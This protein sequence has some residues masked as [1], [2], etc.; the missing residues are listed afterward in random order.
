MYDEV[1]ENTK[2]LCEYLT[3]LYGKDIGEGLLKK[4]KDNLFGFHGLAW[5]VA[6]RSIE[7]FCLYFLQD[8][9]IPKPNNAARKLAPVHY[10]MWHE[11][12]KMLVHDEFDKIVMAEPRGT[13]KTTTLDFGVTVWAHCYKVSYYTIVM[14]K[15]EGDAA[16]FIINV[17]RAFEDNLY[18]R[19]AFGI[20]LDPKK[21]IVNREILELTNGT[22][23]QALSSTSS[24]RGKKY[25]D[26]RPSLII[27]DDA[28]SKAD[29]ITAEARDKKYN[30]WTQ[31]AEYA[32][33]KAVY[34][35]GKKI[36]MA[37]KFIVLGT[38][39]HSS[40]L[41]SRLLKSNKYRHILRRAVDFDVD[42]YFN[43]EI[44]DG[45]LAKA[46]A[47]WN[48]FRKIYG[49][50]RLPG[51]KACAEEFYSMHEDD[52]KFNT[53]WPDKFDCL[54]LATDYYNDPIAFKQEMQN[55][56]SK[57]GIRWFK[58][59]Q[60]QNPEEINSHN[61]IKTMLCIDPAN[62]LDRKADFTA[63][64]VG[65]VADTGFR[66]IRKGIIE[67]LPFD[68]YCMAV[69]R[70]L[71]EYPDITHIDIE[72]NTYQG[73][74]VIKIKEL[75]AKT[76]ELKDRSLIFINERAIGNKDDRINTIVGGINNGQIIF[77]E[78]DADFIAQIH[79]F[80]GQDFSEYDDAPD[81]VAR[82]DTDVKSI[83][84]PCKVKIFDRR[85][86]GV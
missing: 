3:K 42:K 54:E 71:M 74:D 29:I 14:G 59:I 33:D 72:K 17:R 85:L 37:T 48:K 69:V 15:T 35:N 27:A 80:A 68:D 66:Y 76:P 5:M 24:I 77:N 22:E 83:H 23:I 86:L 79:D 70:F 73:A 57:I 34:R 36:K 44:I 50:D 7:F 55:D 47:L 25:G 63:I 62:S 26:Y 40:C 31:D 45:P 19:K 65:S 58:S 75:I 53:I 41:M 2:I 10:E 6:K 51:A 78:E 49:N 46:S 32:G 12:E 1:R 38:V 82:F 16:N 8:T 64:L 20:L 30:M 81:C 56:A 18:I 43:G 39:L 60:T 52:M 11:A 9:F 61:F 84:M 13:S 28:Q 67:R 21:Y 4:F